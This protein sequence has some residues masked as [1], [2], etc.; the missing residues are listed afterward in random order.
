MAEKAVLMKEVKPLFAQA[1]NLALEVTDD[2]EEDFLRAN[3]TM[4][5]R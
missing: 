2:E 5:P 3:P 4:V 1:I